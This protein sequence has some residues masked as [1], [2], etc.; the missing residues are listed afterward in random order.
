M[1]ELL[2]WQTPIHTE[3]KNCTCVSMYNV[4]CATKEYFALGIFAMYV[5]VDVRM[6]I[7]TPV[8]CSGRS[9]HAL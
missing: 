5:H 6:C 3:E 7:I 8:G 9:W 1:R 4:M 2:A